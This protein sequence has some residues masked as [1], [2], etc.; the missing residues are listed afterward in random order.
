MEPRGAICE[1]DAKD[2]RSTLWVSSQGVQH[3]PAGGGRHD[4]EDRLGQA[5][6]A[7]RRRGR[8][9][10]HEDLR[11]SGI[12][13]GGV[14]L[15]HAQAHGE[16]DSRPPGGL[17]VRRAGPRPCLDRRDG[18]RQGLPL[19][20]LPHHDLRGTR[21]LSQPLQRLHP[22]AGRQLDAERPLPDAG[23]LRERE[24]RDDQHRADRRL[25]RRRAARGGLPD[26]ALRRPHRARDRPDA[27]RDPRPQLHQAQP[28][29]VQDG[30]RRHLRLGR[31]RDGDAQGHGEGRLEGLRRAPRAIGSQG[32]VARHRHGD[33][34]REML[35]R[36]A[37]DGEGQ[38]QR[39][40]H[41]HALSSATRPTARAT[42]RRSRQIASARLG[43]DV[44][45]IRIVQGD[46]DVVP[47]GFTG[48]SRTIADQRRGDHGR[49]RQDH[50]Q[51]QAAGGRPARGQRRRHRLQGRRVPDRRHRP[52]VSLFDVAKAPTR[53]EPSTTS[54]RA[55]P[56]PTPSPTAAT[57]A[58]SRS[59]PTPARS[60]S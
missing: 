37:R 34:C 54:S 53:G 27:G 16:V 26:G 2:D 56:K 25:S 19:H 17:P 36:R 46:S 41:D 51:G 3:D 60:R 57:S 8:R 22:D 52:H 48:G 45:R 10:R 21:R 5:A 12:S 14:G 38:V 13:D 23:D 44:E 39:R 30:A 18:A 49:G 24:G 1:Y 6:R 4:P 40:R 28:A 47:E 59:I 9:L 20:R 29:P 7:H 43:I 32:Q 11:A 15:A 42:R 50:R 35:G 55:R 33:L 31:L 58:S